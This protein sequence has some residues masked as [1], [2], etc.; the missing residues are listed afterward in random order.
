MEKNF[1]ILLYR[2]FHAQ[3]NALRAHM[4][5]LGL[6]A[7]QPKLVAYVAEHGPCRQRELAEYF[8]L[9]PAAISRMVASLE[10]GGFVSLS[11]DPANRRCSLVQATGR[12]LGAA[13]AWR[14]RCAQENEQALRDFTPQERVRF[15]AYLDRVCRNY[16][17]VE[18]ETEG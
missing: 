6:G 18:G 11:A 17:Q 8:S 3:R 1:H 5:A 10:R 2:A 4:R 7:G 14:D 15:Y 13:Q 16:G 9:D 12:G